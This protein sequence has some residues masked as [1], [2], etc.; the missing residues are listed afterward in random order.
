M[1]TSRLL[2]LQ[3]SCT[4]QPDV[5][6]VFSRAA[7]P[8]EAVAAATNVLVFSFPPKRFWY[9]FYRPVFLHRYLGHRPCPPTP[10]DVGRFLVFPAASS[11]S[12]SRLI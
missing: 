3:S 10:I 5:T 8:I 2:S 12:T 1:V 4:A 11:P 9:L 6:P 7:A